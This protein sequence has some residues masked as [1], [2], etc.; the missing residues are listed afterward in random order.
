MGVP[1]HCPRRDLLELEMF[2]DVLI[3]LRNGIPVGIEVDGKEIEHVES[4]CIKFVPNDVI[5]LE[6]TLYVGVI[7]STDIET[8][9]EHI[10]SDG[11]VRGGKYLHDMEFPIHKKQR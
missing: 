9:A 3:R 2:A 1:G 4:A 7:K 10:V 8:G 11:A 5:K 6:L